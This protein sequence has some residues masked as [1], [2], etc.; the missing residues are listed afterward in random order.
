M[1]I[2]FLSYVRNWLLRGKWMI[3][4][5]L[6]GTN[7]FVAKIAILYYIYS[8]ISVVERRKEGKNA[9]FKPCTKERRKRKFPRLVLVLASIQVRDI[10]QRRRNRR[11]KRKVSLNF[12]FLLHCF[13]VRCTYYFLSLSPTSNSVWVTLNANSVA[14]SVRSFAFCFRSMRTLTYLY[15]TKSWICTDFDQFLFL[16]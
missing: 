12:S 6:L 13:I 15:K 14:C 4:S 2:L 16:F 3:W 7:V 1:L 9:A 8:Y 5:G 11:G 10:D